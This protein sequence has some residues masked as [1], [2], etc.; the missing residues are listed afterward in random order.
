MNFLF[1]NLSSHTGI[2]ILRVTVIHLE[3][4]LPMWQLYS[5][6]KKKKK[7]VLELETQCSERSINKEIICREK[8]LRKIMSVAKLVVDK[9]EYLFHNI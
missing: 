7:K 5:D 1:L 2:V 3:N 9:R 8:I 4:R 6:K